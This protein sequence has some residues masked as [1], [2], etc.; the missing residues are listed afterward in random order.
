V[1]EHKL[2]AADNI[3]FKKIFVQ[4]REDV[5]KGF[6]IFRNEEFCGY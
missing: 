1:E 2:R 3:M 4:K 6:R 5:S